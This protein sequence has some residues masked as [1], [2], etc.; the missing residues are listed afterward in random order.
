MNVSLGLLAHVDAGKTTF[1]ERLLFHTGSIRKAG[2][3]DHRD[4]FLDSHEIERLRGI[5]VYSKEAYFER[6]EKR[7]F[8]LDTPG[9]TDFAA[10]TERGVQVIDY[11]VLII[12]CV[13]GVQ[14]HTETLWKLLAKYKVPVMIFI[15][16]SDRAGADFEKVFSQIKKKLS[17]DAVFFE[18]C[19]SV[20]ENNSLLEELAQRDDVLLEN[21]FSDTCTK[22][23]AE[24]RIGEMIKSR[25]LFP[26]FLGSALQ[27]IGFDNVIYALENY[28]VSDN[29]ENEEF[30]ASVY[31]IRYDSS[32]TKMTY[33][34]I[35]SGSIGVKDE[36]IPG[37]KINE[38]YICHGEKLIP[39]SKGYAGGLYGVTGLSDFICGDKIEKGKIL[40][41]KYN[42]YPMLGAGVEFDKTKC[43][44]K[45]MLGY[46]K[47]LEEEEPMLSALWDENTKQITVRVMGEI[48]L[49]VLKFIIKQRFNE[50]VNFGECKIFYMETIKEAVVGRG[51]FEPLRHYAE[52][53]L[54]LVPK[55][56]D[57]GITFSSE[58]STEILENSFQNLV[59]THIF[60]KTHKGV[61]TGS[62]ITD[63]EF[64]L[65]TG[66][67]HL[68]HTEGGDFREAVY[69]AVR[70][71]LRKAQSVILEPWYTFKIEAGREFAGRIMSD[72][73]RMY[74]SFQPPEAEEN[75]IIIK[76]EAPVETFR[77]YPR[78]LA[79]FTGGRALIFL[80]FCGY[81][82][83]HN[84]QEIIEKTGYNADRDTQNTA[85]SVF[86]SHGA[87]FTV[88]WDE[89]DSYMHCELSE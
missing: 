47:I 25:K 12:S 19:G 29:S 67:S 71:G 2:R 41:S 13:E 4:T 15:N 34:K 40:K 73:Q 42:F 60:E 3:V 37:V 56:R 59:R 43:S 68:K 83:C 84:G 49:E 26:C 45:T 89:A 61:L 48:Q 75:E 20:L 8:L 64:V 14:S 70:Q 69:R 1:G 79:S 33:L 87:G 51:H 9:H 80:G 78:E 53:H 62:P 39:V 21:Y 32:R 63:I 54:R 88:K 10:E 74:G 77:N 38:M 18:N 23:L 86:C 30:S 16:K 24:S 50:E 52:V 11:A 22:S 72:I 5:T 65:L 66:R 36:I 57:S 44:E 6:G 28:I 58:C 17:D 27:D 31:K 81:R 35:N 82:E 7:F 76:G 46:L 85:D 55:E